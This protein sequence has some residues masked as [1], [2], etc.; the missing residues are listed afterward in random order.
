MTA[1]TFER[2]TFTI[3]RALE[4]F[5]EKEL[6]MQIGHSRPMW[7]IALIKELVDN[8]LD[9][10]EAAEIAP[11]IT[12]TV[13]P[14]AV[15]IADNGPGLPAVTLERSLD[16]L[17]RV[18]DKAHYVSPTRGQLGNALKCVWAAPFVASGGNHGRVMIT[19]HGQQHI[20]DVRLD[21]I[22][23]RP[24]I[25]IDRLPSDVKS[26]TIVTMCWP[27]IA[28]YLFGGFY[29]V[30][31]IGDLADR[32]AAFNP[33]LH[34]EVDDAVH[35]RRHTYERSAA[36]PHWLPNRPTS[37]HWYT[38]EQWYNLV[39][40]ELAAARLNGGA[41]TVN[42]FVAKFAGLS[43]TAKRKAVTDAAGLTG[44]SL[45]ALVVNNAID[46][47]RAA[48][49][50]QAMRDQSRLIK[51]AVLGVIGKE[52]FTHHMT[53][54]YHAEPDSIR[55]YKADGEADGL[56]SILEMAFGIYRPDAQDRPATIA[57]GANWSPVL[58]PESF[59][60]LREAL[61]TARV[62]SGDPV[63]LVLHLACPR[64][65]TTDKGKGA[66]VL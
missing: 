52:H 51:P 36:Q 63:A 43:G 40:G 61:S 26:G 55:Y 4:F 20:V 59:T 46:R 58:R 27:Q 5:S 24:D 56:P 11:Q 30:P 1:Q 39:A 41:P 14:D 57:V 53:T 54:A 35:G 32:Y 22:A 25:T 10:C 64:I 9:A 29:S 17:V 16:Y 44:A 2:T 3:N 15:H 21:A 60:Q 47:E 42:E 6:T 49:L 8:A 7:A 62:D 13:E 48:A 65:K 37:P 23:G 45:E 12:I 38:A 33:D 34:L 31:T 66:I 50:L 18:S 19:A 28:S